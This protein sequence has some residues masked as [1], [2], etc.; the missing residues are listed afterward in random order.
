MLFPSYN[1]LFM[2]LP[3]VL[4]ANHLIAVKYKNLLLTIASYIFYAYWDYR[5]CSLI[6]ISTIWDYR[7][8]LA[9]YSTS[10]TSLRTRLLY[11]SILFNLALLG[12]FKYANFF[13]DSITSIYPSI[14]LSTLDIVL[15]IGISFFT[16]QSMSYTIDIYRKR[17]T[18]TSSFIDFACY[19]SMFPQLIAGPIVRYHQ[20]ADQLRERHA[21]VS[22]IAHGIRQFSVGLAKKVLIADACGQIADILF[23]STTPS[24]YTAWFAVIAYSLQIYFD[25]SGYSDMAI[26]LAR[27]FGFQLPENFNFPYQARSI[28]EFWRRW[29]ISLSG[30]FREYLYIPLGGSHVAAARISANLMITMLLCGLWHGASWNF[31]LWGGYHGFLLALERPFKDRNTKVPALLAVPVTSILVMIGWVLF[32]SD[33][34]FQVQIWLHAMLGHNGFAW[35]WELVT[36]NMISLL[37]ALQLACWLMPK[38][39]LKF[40]DSSFFKDILY[41]LLFILCSIVI[42]GSHSSPFL[43]YQF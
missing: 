28:T 19:I 10:F 15:P 32:R 21:T 7:L 22:D 36:K 12:Y 16:F 24:F 43:Y 4:L 31:V 13:I 25:F 26:G 3:L 35:Q 14:S 18:P 17:I 38:I 5:F 20:I 37:C 6:L 29:H 34:L 11:L 1:F 8:G 27:M 30:W 23:E 33:S 9:I 39:E 40:S 42:L 2:F 41:A